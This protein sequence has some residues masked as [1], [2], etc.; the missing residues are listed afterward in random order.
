M[1]DWEKELKKYGLKRWK[2]VIRP[3]DASCNS[4]TKTIYLTPQHGWAMFL[5]EVAHALCNKYNKE[6]NAPTGHHAIW[7]DKLTALYEEHLSDEHTRTLNEVRGIIEG[8]K[9]E[10]P[11]KPEL[12]KMALTLSNLEIAEHA[13]EFHA[14][15]QALSDILSALKEKGKV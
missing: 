9:K 8:M 1:S 13:V 11:P 14:Y 12:D 2:V 6:M 4:K 3:H 5:H 7:G 10:V 15:N